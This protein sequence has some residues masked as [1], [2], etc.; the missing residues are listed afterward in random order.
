MQDVLKC[1]QK[2]LLQIALLKGITGID[3]ALEE[4]G[5]SSDSNRQL[6]GE[7]TTQDIFCVIC[8]NST[9]CAVLLSMFKV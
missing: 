5:F 2:Q 1:N 8:R 7:Y 4:A 9:A 6:Q 3:Q